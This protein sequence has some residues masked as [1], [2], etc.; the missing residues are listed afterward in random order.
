MVSRITPSIGFRQVPPGPDGRIR[1]GETGAS[2]EPG[3]LGPPTG[4]TVGGISYAAISPIPSPPPGSTGNGARTLLWPGPCGSRR[5]GGRVPHRRGTERHA[6]GL[7]WG[8]DARAPGWA[9]SPHSC[10]SRGRAPPCR[11]AVLPMR[12]SRHAW[13]PLVVLRGPSWMSFWGWGVDNPSFGF[14]SGVHLL[15]SPA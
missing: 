14:G 7:G 15:R 12:K 8:R 4:S 5:E 3:R 6:T 11:A 1:Q 13:W 2:C 9:S 10:C